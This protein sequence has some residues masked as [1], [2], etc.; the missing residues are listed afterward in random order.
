MFTFGYAVS[1]EGSEVVFVRD[2][3]PGDEL[4]F[5]TPDEALR[6]G[7]YALDIERA[8]AK[9]PLAFLN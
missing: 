5:D 1:D 2:A 9:G 7:L 8:A 3:G 6:A 4:V